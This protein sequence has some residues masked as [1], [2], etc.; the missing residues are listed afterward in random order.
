MQQQLARLKAAADQKRRD[1]EAALNAAIE[2]K[3]DVA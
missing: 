3:G 2:A 1:Q